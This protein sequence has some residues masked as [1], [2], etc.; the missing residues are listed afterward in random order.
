ML[1]YKSVLIHNIHIIHRPRIYMPVAAVWLRMD[2]SLKVDFA[3]WFDMYMGRS[4]KPSFPAYSGS[5]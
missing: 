1:Y 4:F 2:C 5:A 3:L